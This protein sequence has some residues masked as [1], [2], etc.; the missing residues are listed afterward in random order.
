MLYPI[1]PEAR[2]MERLKAISIPE[3]TSEIVAIA[4]RFHKA[5]YKKNFPK[6]KKIQAVSLV[7]ICH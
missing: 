5:C 7:Q 3:I 4:T 2:R 1:S 6:S